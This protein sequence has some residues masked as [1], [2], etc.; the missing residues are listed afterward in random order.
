MLHEAYLEK[1]DRNAIAKFL[2]TCNKI[3]AVNL[4]V[5]QTAKT[6]EGREQ[7]GEDNEILSVAEKEIST[8]IG[9]STANFSDGDVMIKEFKAF[10]AEM[11]HLGWM[12]VS[13][14]PDW[15]GNFMKDECT[16]FSFSGEY[17]KH[18]EK[19]SVSKKFLRKT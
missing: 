9:F 11:E 17:V 16:G 19:T 4:W 7:K 6:T 3:G 12:V 13:N 2:D 18:K 1:K 8:R 5:K 14:G 10:N 15:A